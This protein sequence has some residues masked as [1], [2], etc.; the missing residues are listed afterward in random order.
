M[1]PWVALGAGTLAS[2][3]ANVAVGAVDLIGRAVAGWPAIA[4]LV[5]IKML[6]GLLDGRST[7]DTGDPEQP[8]DHLPRQGR[9]DHRSAG[10]GTS[11]SRVAAAPPRPSGSMISQSPAAASTCAGASPMAAMSATS[12][13]YGVCRVR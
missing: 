12:R 6:A 7:K 11:S 5:A 3:A 13:P 4:M 10:S 9:R 1:L 8:A 2:L